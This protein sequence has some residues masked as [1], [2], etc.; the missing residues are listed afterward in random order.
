MSIPIVDFHTHI[1]P[2]ALAPRALASLSAH[3]DYEP[4][5]DMTR[6][7]LLARMDEWGISRS[8]VMPVVTKASQVRPVNEWAA[9][10][11][12]ER[13]TSFGGVFPNGPDPFA[14]VDMVVSLGLPGVKLHP[15]YQDFEIDEPRMLK[16]YDYILS[17]GLILLFH[18]GFDPATG[19]VYR[20][21]P[22]RVAYV[23]DEMKG[24]SIVAAHLGSSQMW[25]DVLRYLCGKNVYMD[26]S[27]GF[28]YYGKET[29]LRVL[30]AHG[31]DRLLFGSDSPWSSAK[32][33]I[34]TLRSLSLPEE[35]EEAILG[36]NALKLLGL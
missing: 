9:A 3:C 22:K 19:P 34:D 20:S 11:P 32:K 17:K 33:E 12:S 4:V 1:F 26:T 14:D 6:N 15:E 23:V 24:G 29:F 16:L 10:L 31:A 35:T 28:D 7:G 5:S 27:M 21:D 13:L 8:V 30:E 25:E 2:D 18:T 36:G